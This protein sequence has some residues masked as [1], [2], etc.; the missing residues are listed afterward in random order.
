MLLAKSSLPHFFMA[1]GY[2]FIFSVSVSDSKSVSFHLP[3]VLEDR[4][5]SRL[6][7][8]CFFFCSWRQPLNYANTH[9]NEQPEC[10]HT[11]ANC[12]SSGRPAKA[13]QFA[14]VCGFFIY[15]HVFVCVCACGGVRLCVARLPPAEHI[16][17]F[18]FFQE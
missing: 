7:A 16:L 3:L 10:T 18:F 5:G 17:T 13:P 14:L 6:F 8:R 4:L 12:K 9:T 1:R 15:A 2:F 11:C